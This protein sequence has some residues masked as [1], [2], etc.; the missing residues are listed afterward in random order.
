MCS[1]KLPCLWM[2]GRSRCNGEHSSHQGVPRH[3]CNAWEATAWEQNPSLLANL[4]CEVTH[5]SKRTFGWGSC[6]W[7]IGPTNSLNGQI[8]GKSYKGKR[9]TCGVSRRRSHLT[10]PSKVATKRVRR[11]VGQ[12]C[13]ALRMLG[14]EASRPPLSPCT[15]Y[16]HC[17]ETRSGSSPCSFLP[18]CTKQ[19]GQGPLPAPPLCLSPE[20]SQLGGEATERHYQ[21]GPWGKQMTQC[22][23]HLKEVH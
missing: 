16:K 7:F 19:K 18:F 13:Q 12:D 20:F 22:K 4:T 17:P 8:T 6:H 11:E 15:N 23:G 14:C 2:V 1:F 5:K 21:S 10:C 9:P 3:P